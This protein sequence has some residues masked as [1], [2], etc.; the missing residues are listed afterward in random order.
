LFSTG[1]AW[2]TAPKNKNLQSLGEVFEKALPLQQKELS[3]LMLHEAVYDRTG[4]ALKL[5]LRI[6]PGMKWNLGEQ[7]ATFETC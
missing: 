6:L 2:R 1:L 3:H 4:N 7:G 5:S